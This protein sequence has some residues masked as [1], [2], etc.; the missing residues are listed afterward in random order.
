MC[1]PT[2]CND[3]HLKQRNI[4]VSCRICTPI[5]VPICHQYDIGVQ[6]SVKD[7]SLFTRIWTTLTSYICLGVYKRSATPQQEGEQ[8][9]LL[10]QMLTTSALL[11][12]G[13][14]FAF[15]HPTYWSMAQSTSH[16]KRMWKSG[17]KKYCIRLHL[18]F[19]IPIS[20]FAPFILL[21]MPRW[22]PCSKGTKGWIWQAVA[23]WILDLSMLTSR[24]SYLGI[25]EAGLSIGQNHR[26]PHSIK[27]WEKT[28]ACSC[29]LM[30][31]KA[32]MV[33]L[34]G[35]KTMNMMTTTMTNDELDRMWFMWTIWYTHKN[36]CIVAT[37]WYVLTTMTLLMLLLFTITVYHEK[38]RAPK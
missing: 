2:I 23:K 10:N 34:T 20:A 31:L 30:L 35:T 28:A 1:M 4:I 36:I 7:S 9:A 25:M 16:I 15:P 12:H 13:P 19:I 5:F 24:C 11:R 32:G 38:L 27:C 18:K 14:I 8:D 37:W 6:R 3:T 22:K 21:G 26:F 33:L 29:L 17:T